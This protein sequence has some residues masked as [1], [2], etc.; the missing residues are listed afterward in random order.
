M[1]EEELEKLSLGMEVS[2]FNIDYQRLFYHKT[3]GSTFVMESSPSLWQI[4][5]AIDNAL[6]SQIDRESVSHYNTH[7][8]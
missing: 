6:Y 2:T 5:T 3:V 8:Q 7:I 1:P 4:D